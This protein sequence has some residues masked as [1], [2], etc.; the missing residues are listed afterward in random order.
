MLFV[1]LTVGRPHSPLSPATRRVKEV[2]EEGLAVENGVF[3]W[4]LCS[5]GRHVHNS[6]LSAQ[7]EYTRMKLYPRPKG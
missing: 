5:Y 3:A 2:S 4:I 1:A 7:A 6:L